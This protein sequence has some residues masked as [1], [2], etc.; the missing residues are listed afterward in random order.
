M[1]QIG[2]FPQSFLIFLYFSNFPQISCISPLILFGLLAHRKGPGYATGMASPKEGAHEWFFCCKRTTAYVIRC[3]LGLQCVASFLVQFISVPK[4]HIT[5][6]SI[7]FGL[8]TRIDAGGGGG[9]GGCRCIGRRYGDVP[10]S[11]P[12]RRSLAYQFTINAPL[13]CPRFQFLGKKKAFSALFFMAKI[14]AIKAQIFV[15]KSP[16][17]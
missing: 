4:I 16:N 10:W 12:I 13:T 15:P 17:F 11:W 1:G 5:Q 8:P 7:N 3:L 14:S 2:I 9:G 6:V